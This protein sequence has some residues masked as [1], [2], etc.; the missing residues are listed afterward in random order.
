[1]YIKE[2]VMGKIN[3]LFKVLPSLLEGLKSTIFIFFAVLVLCIP[4]GF[5]VSAIHHFS[6]NGIKKITK[7]YI[8]V[9]RG[10]PLLLQLMFIFFGLPYIGIKMGR[11]SAVLLAM[12]LNYAAYYA[13]IF[14][15]GINSIDKSQFEA[16]KVLGLSKYYGFIKIIAPQTMKNA[17]P[18]VCNEVITLL[19]DTSLIY[20]LG[21]DDLLKASKTMAN[22][23]ASLIPFA[24]AGAIYLIFTAI[25]TKVLAKIE[26]RIEF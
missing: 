23:T 14:R 16:V 1:M 8:Y 21:L 13:E 24:L 6:A 4:L 25:L 26:R 18:S 3:L 15:G 19:K 9:M 12:I 10:S 20:I 11:V 17:F 2:K 22:Y 7:A 5:L